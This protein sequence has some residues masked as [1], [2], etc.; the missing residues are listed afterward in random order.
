MVSAD[1]ALESH[2]VRERLTATTVRKGFS[3]GTP[4]STSYQR[5]IATA[6]RL[7]V[8]AH[9]TEK[10]SPVFQHVISKVGRRVSKE[11]P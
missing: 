10:S 3:G 2:H 6:G 8:A 9:D 11:T 5:E 4:L 1:V 7:I